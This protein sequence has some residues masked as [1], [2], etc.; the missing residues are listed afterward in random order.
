MPEK[1]KCIVGYKTGVN[2]RGFVYG[3]VFSK[4]D[5]CC[6]EFEQWFY[7]TGNTKVDNFNSSGA[8]Y[9]ERNGFNFVTRGEK[10]EIEL[11]VTNPLRTGTILFCPFCQAEIEIKEVEVVTLKPKHKQ[12]F[13]GYEEVD[14]IKK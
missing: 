2:E 6:D 4:L 9:S 5:V 13:D 7:S 1:K 12:V 8:P 10:L 11:R 3:I 14:V